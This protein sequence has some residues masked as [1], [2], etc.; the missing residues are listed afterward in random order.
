MKKVILPPDFDPYGKELKR[1]M[2]ELADDKNMVHMKRGNPTLVCGALRKEKGPCLM[3]AGLGTRHVGYGRCKLHGGNNTGPKTPE[4]KAKVAQ[5]GRIHGLYSTVLSPVEKE[6]YESLLEKPKIDLSHEIRMLQ[7]KIIGYLQDW[8]KR[9]EYAEKV[10]GVHEAER[11]M[12]VYYT[13][14]DS[15]TKGCYHAG[16]I[17]DKPLIRALNELAKM[18]EK[19]ARLDPDNNEDLLSSVNNE[20]AKASHGKV[21]IAWAG[22][23]AQYKKGDSGNEE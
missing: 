14:G 22:R 1:A 21:T 16:T 2:H 23:P 15:G 3:N 6:I 12:R 4:G 11:R 18:I 17:E 8:R 9:Y 13:V 19:N 5:N 7:A 10:F 20:L